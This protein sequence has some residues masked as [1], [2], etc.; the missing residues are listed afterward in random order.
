GSHDYFVAGTFT[1]TITLLDDGVAVAQTTSTANV[2]S[3]QA[4]LPVSLPTAIFRNTLP[5]D[6][7]AG[8]QIDW[9][10]GSAASAALLTLPW[11]YANGWP[12][13]YSGWPYSSY[14]WYW[15]NYDNYTTQI[16]TTYGTHLYSTEGSETI[17]TTVT[18]DPGTTAA[19]AN[20][21]ITVADGAL[22]PVA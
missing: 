7:I 14:W 13:A 5:A 8:A 2:A 6:R 3:A 18:D 16:F 9:G 21:T 17:S 22:A 12:Y 19:T 1:L 20:Q 4:G 11:P 15:P 10:D